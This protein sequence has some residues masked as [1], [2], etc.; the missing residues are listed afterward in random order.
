MTVAIDW[1]PALGLRLG[2]LIDGL[3]LVFALAITGIGAFIIAY[4]G[5]YLEGHP[6]RGQS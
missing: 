6:Q 4:S 5:A 3:S 1:V 2:F